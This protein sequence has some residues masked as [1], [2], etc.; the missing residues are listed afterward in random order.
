MSHHRY[1]ICPASGKV[2]YGERK[3]IKLEMRQAASDRSQARLDN[4]ACSRRE[5]R[6]YSCSDCRGWHLTSQ[7]DRFVR[8]VPMPKLA[9]HTP[10]PAA[11]A[12]ERMVIATGLNTSAAA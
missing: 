4:V 8:L 10:G 9:V 12:I 7:Q 6:S 3:D 2:R 11:R 1:P 5:V